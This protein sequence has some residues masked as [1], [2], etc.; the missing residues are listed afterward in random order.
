ME[1]LVNEVVE[2]LYKLDEIVGTEIRDIINTEG[3][4][5]DKD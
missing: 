5:N 2:E 4:C 3:I 1:D